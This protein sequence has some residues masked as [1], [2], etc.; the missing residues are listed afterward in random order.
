M[1]ALIQRTLL[2]AT[3]AVAALLVT[4]TAPAAVPIEHVE[5]VHP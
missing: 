1:L 2:V 4:S 5:A 3:L